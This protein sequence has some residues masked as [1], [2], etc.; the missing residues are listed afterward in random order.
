[1][2][3]AELCRNIL[4]ITVMKIKT[5]LIGIAA[6]FCTSVYAQDLTQIDVAG[7]DAYLFDISRM[8]DSTYKFTFEIREYAGDVPEPVSIQKR[9]T[10]LNRVTVSA[11]T[12]RELS[13]AELEQLR[14]ESYDYDKGIYSAAENITIGFHPSRTPS[15]AAGVIE[16]DGMGKSRFELE[17]KSYKTILSGADVYLYDSVP[18]RVEELRTDCFIPLVMYASSCIGPDYDI[19]KP[20]HYFI[21][22]VTITC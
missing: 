18:F 15:I 7:Y 6:I 14:A 5:L 8:Q 10:F 19:L 1:M 22:G 13:T 17:L 4:D 9:T 11:F 2:F 3:A 21:I 20:P 12:W 16:V